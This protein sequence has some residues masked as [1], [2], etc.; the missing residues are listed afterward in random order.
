MNLESWGDKNVD[1]TTRRREAG[2]FKSN[3]PTAAESK[4]REDSLVRK[5]PVRALGLLRSQV[6]L[7][8][9]QATAMGGGFQASTR[10]VG[11]TEVIRDQ[12][13]SDH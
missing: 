1:I 13:R 5:P 9:M 2:H 8:S 3:S 7:D 11:V 4:N 10:A 6:R 12:L